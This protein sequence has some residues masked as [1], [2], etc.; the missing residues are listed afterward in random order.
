MIYSRAPYR[1]SFGG[2]GSDVP[3][4]CWDHGGEVVSTT[5]NRYA[6]AELHPDGDD[7]TIRSIDFDTERSFDLGRLEYTDDDLDLIKA[8]VN[9][10]DLPRGVDLTVET[11]LPAGS[12]MG[13]S[14]SVAVALIGAL[15]AFTGQ[16]LDADEMASLAYHAEREDLGVKGGYQDQY[17][18]AFGGLNHIAFADTETT[19]SPLDIPDPLQKE[20]EARSLL[21]YTGETRDSSEIH[22]DMDRQYRE[23]PTDEKDRRDR[24]KAVAV[25]MEA[26]LS[27]GDLTQF[28]QLLHE[29][30]EV[31]RRLSD[32]ISNPRINEIYETARDNG[33]AGGKILGAGGGGH[34]LVYCEPGAT[35]D[36]QRSLREYNL[37]RVPFTFEPH[38]VQTWVRE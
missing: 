22:E 36:V 1:I 4:Y 5:V 34:L 20:L 21:Y 18:A 17:A 23:Q 29:G 13:G 19:V 26:A 24:L 12:G 9:Q 32:R 37:Q 8:V 30:W 16:S 14:S 28:G 2:G 7:I 25:E 6:H 11:D 10:F 15:A 38:G 33:A 35:F 3:P 27:E 31:K